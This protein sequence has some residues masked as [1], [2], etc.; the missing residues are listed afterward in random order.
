MFGQAFEPCQPDLRQS[1]Q[2]L[3]AVDMD[4]PLG[5]LLLAMI[6]AEVTIAEID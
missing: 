1:P 6:D 2:A 5:E 4:G 3:D